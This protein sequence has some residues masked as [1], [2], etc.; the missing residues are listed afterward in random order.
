SGIARATP[1]SAWCRE[2]TSPSTASRRDCATAAEHGAPG[3]AFVKAK[4][5]A[6]TRERV[7]AEVNRPSIRA[8]RREELRAGEAGPP[9][10]R[11]DYVES[12]R[13]LVS[14]SLEHDLVRTD[15]CRRPKDDVDLLWQPA[16]RA[17][18]GHGVRRGITASNGGERGPDERG[19]A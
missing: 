10:A 9:R 15:D 17:L 11:C 14:L 3:A 12:H 7:P 5:V 19:R 6:D 16:H 18:A 4:K 2:S 13:A 8:A 1:T